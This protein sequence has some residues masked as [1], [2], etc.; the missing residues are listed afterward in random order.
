MSEITLNE[1]QYKNFGR[2][3][4]LSNGIIK[5]IVTIDVGPR[6]IN[7]SFVDGENIFWEDIDRLETTDEVEECYGSPW[8]LYGGHRLWTSPE[9]SPRTYYADNDPVSYK[10]VPGGAVFTQ[11]TQKINQVQCEITVTLAPDSSDVKVTHRIT[12]KNAWDITFAIWALSVMSQGGLEI[13]PQPTSD[14]GLLN[15][16]VIGIWPYAKFTDS[17]I[18]W[19]DR[20]IAMKQDPEIAPAY[21]LGINSEHGFAMYFNHGDVFVKKFDLVKGGTYPDGGM[22]FESYV[23]G[24]FL[25]CES[26]GELKS[27]APGEWVEHSERW[28]LSKASAPERFD[29]E[30]LDRLAEKYI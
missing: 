6:I 28:S 13:I 29:E 27:V 1:I 20:Y 22:S 24:N 2:C 4:E 23:C 3:V 11:K 15:N 30:L 5:V 7:Y 9:A 21:E 16:R 8:Y 12:N 25:E 17:R 19:G 18:T 10:A 26:L 14:T